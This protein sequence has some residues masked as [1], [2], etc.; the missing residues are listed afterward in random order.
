VLPGASTKLQVLVTKVL[1]DCQDPL[2]LKSQKLNWKRYS[3]LD[4]L[5]LQPPMVIIDGRE[6]R[7]EEA[8][9][10]VDAFL[11]AHSVLSIAWEPYNDE[12]LHASCSVQC[13][14]KC[15]RNEKLL[16]L[17]YLI[18]LY[19]GTAVLD[20]LTTSCRYARS[21]ICIVGPLAMASSHHK[22]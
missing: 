16:I 7:V 21:L 13:D 2:I 6:Q 15:C 1:K 19:V 20:T 22:A 14:V 11:A 3:S 4:L 10:A 8:A 18:T 5:L 9:A 12:V 17:Y